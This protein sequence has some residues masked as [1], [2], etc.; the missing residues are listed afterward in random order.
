MTWRCTRCGKRSNVPARWLAGENIP[1][2]CGGRGWEKVTDM[3][4]IEALRNKIK[5]AQK[6]LRAD[7]QKLADLAS[8][9]KPGDII[10]LVE[11]GRFS[12][13]PAGTRLLVTYVGP[14]SRDFD[15]TVV[16]FKKNGEPATKNLAGAYITSRDEYK[17]VGHWEEHDNG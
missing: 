9:C 2:E 13:C 6:Q 17:V 7:R 16:S 12:R 8:G 4:G 3:T 15:L 5:A 11:Q 14:H 10:E 1:C